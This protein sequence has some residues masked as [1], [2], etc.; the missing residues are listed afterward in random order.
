MFGQHCL[1]TGPALPAFLYQV[2]N[3]S[4]LTVPTP[5]SVPTL[6]SE[7]AACELISAF[8][9]VSLDPLRMLA[10]CVVVIII[11]WLSLLTL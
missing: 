7:I 11:P 1:Q 3:Y 8:L 10:S 4:L 5:C 2:T 9:R 6:P